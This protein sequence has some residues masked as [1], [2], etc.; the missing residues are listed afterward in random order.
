MRK[1]GAQN[2]R[3]KRVQKEANEHFEKVDF[4]VIKFISFKY[5]I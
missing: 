4:N 2:V 5:Y 1:G 3:K